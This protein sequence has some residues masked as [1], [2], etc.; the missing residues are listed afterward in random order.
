MVPG[1]SVTI[2]SPSLINPIQGQTDSQG[3]YYARNLP[4]GNYKVTVTK[5]GFRSTVRDKVAVEVGRTFTIP[6]PLELGVQS[7]TVEVSAA[8]PI[9]DT[10]KSESAATYR[11]ETLTNVP[12]QGRDFT[13]FAKLAPSVNSE[14][15]AG[16][17]SVDGASGSEN[18]FY[19]DG[20]NTS[21]IFNGLNDVGVRTELVQEMQVK[22]GGYEAEFGGAMGGVVSVVTKSGSNDLHGMLYYYYS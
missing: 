9:I 1:A 19:V 5:N 7:Q 16:G 3:F 20:V 6:V 8:P 14:T 2:T 12:V 21:N 18:Q 11:G 13:S 22:S 15:F 17:L 4:S 10:L